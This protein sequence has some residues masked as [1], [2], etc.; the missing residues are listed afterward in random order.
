MQKRDKEESQGLEKRREAMNTAILRL[1][2]P[3]HKEETYHIVVSL[4]RRPDVVDDQVTI[5]LAFGQ[6]D[7]LVGASPEVY[8]RMLVRSEGI[9]SLGGHRSWFAVVVRSALS[10]FDAVYKFK[11][12][13]RGST[14]P[15]ALW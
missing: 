5:S 14:T 7:L 12:A 8:S 4:G 1:D 9:E 11:L 13:S 15:V 10:L 3:I 2:L 6:F